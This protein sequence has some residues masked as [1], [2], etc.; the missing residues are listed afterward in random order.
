M[1]F[2]SDFAE[3]ITTEG[4]DL[5]STPI[6]TKLKIGEAVLEI[7]EHGKICHDRCEIFRTHGRCVM[8]EE[9]VF[10][11]VV[12]SGIVKTND[13]IEIVNSNILI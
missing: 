12:K 7:T 2:R 3:N 10:A 11:K 1:L 4:V 5:I 9:G 6:G 13:H 8:Q